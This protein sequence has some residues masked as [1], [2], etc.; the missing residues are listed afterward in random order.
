MLVVGVNGDDSVRRLNKGPERPL[1]PM[2]DRM[3][4]LAGLACIDYLVG[5]D[6]D[7]PVQTLAALQPAIHCKGGDYKANELPEAPTVRAY[8]GR[9]VVL[10]FVPGYSTT[11][12]VERMQ[13]DGES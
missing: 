7:T 4:V 1:N 11:G 6:E 5:F 12:L 8:G 13:S 3:R 9:V 10:P 2:A